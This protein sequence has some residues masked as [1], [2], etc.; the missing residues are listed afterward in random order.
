MQ[1]SAI[2]FPPYQQSFVCLIVMR[3]KKLYVFYL[4]NAPRYIVFS[5]YGRRKWRVSD[6]FIHAVVMS[7]QPS[8]VN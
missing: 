7:V 6:I 3:N 2:I 4:A 1:R 8:V 5:S